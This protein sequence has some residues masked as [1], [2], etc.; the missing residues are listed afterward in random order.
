M[1]STVIF[2]VC[3]IAA[4]LT[5]LKTR[6]SMFVKGTNSYGNQVEKFRASWLI[7]PIVIFIAGIVI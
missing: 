6:G 5:A 1:I 4:V 2:V 3:L 7:K